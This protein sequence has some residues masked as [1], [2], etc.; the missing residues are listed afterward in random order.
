MNN[1]TKTMILI[2]V[3]TLLIGLASFGYD[4]LSQRF[5]HLGNNLELVQNEKD[6]TEAE[7]GEKKDEDKKDEDKEKIIAPDFTVVD[8]NDDLVKFSDFL[9][10]PIVL[11]FWA[12]W[13]PPC[14]AEMPDINRV[15][16]E[17]GEDVTFMMVD[18][19]DGQRETQEKGTRYIEEQGFSFPVY[20]DTQQD[21]AARYGIRSIPTTIFIDREGNIVAAAQSA[22]DVDTLK[23]GIDLIK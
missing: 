2:L 5:S 16:E 22:L 11:N 9:G 21:A 14:R 18:L 1:K 17:L 23:Q 15:Y 13:C 7:V 12:S 19:V 6:G 8:G 10:K 3:F 4:A 20:Y